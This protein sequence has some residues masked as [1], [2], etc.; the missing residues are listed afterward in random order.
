MSIKLDYDTYKEVSED[1]LSPIVADGLDIDTLK[2]LYQSKLVYLNN[3]RKQCFLDVN[4]SESVFSS[5]D[6]EHVTQAIS[7]TN[8]HIRELILLTLENTL[9]SLTAQDKVS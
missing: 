8:Y 9:E 6:L 5:Q 4:R 2:R 1:L 7:S 3:L